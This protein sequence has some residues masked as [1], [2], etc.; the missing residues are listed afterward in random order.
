MERSINFS[1]ISGEMILDPTQLATV[2]VIEHPDIEEPRK[3]DVMTSEIEG[4]GKLAI[5][6]VI[7]E[8]TMP[9]EN[10]EE[11][12]PERFILTTTNF[13]KLAQGKAMKD[14]LADAMPAIVE[15][16]GNRKKQQERDH[17]TIE[18]AGSPHKGKT[19]PTE[20]RVV[21][22]H[23]AEVNAKLASRGMRLIDP[24]NPDHQKR[25]GITEDMDPGTLNFDEP[26]N[27]QETA[28]DQS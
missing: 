20:A 23:L 7:V 8:V 10:G 4:I 19:S 17:N 14:V 3:L 22:E 1:D 12:E 24:K 26:A 5:K 11:P 6:P 27:E 9:A 2:E 18:W 28:P 13:N 15:T 21:R 25:Y 16:V